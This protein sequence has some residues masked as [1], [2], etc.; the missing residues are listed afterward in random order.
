MPCLEPVSLTRLIRRF[1]RFDT[2]AMDYLECYWDSRLVCS[3]I[4]LLLRVKY[5]IHYFLV[6]ST[7]GPFLYDSVSHCFLVGS[8]RG[9][10]LYM[11]AYLTSFT[12]TASICERTCFPTFQTSIAFLLFSF[13]TNRPRALLIF[14]TVTRVYIVQNS[15]E[16]SFGRILITVA[17]HL[18]DSVYALR[19][20]QLCYVISRSPSKPIQLC[21]AYEIVDCSLN[22]SFKFSLFIVLSRYRILILSVFYS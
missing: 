17:T 5:G 1:S 9:P 2:R 21:L 22:P 8:T 18:R 7:L 16:P 19:L 12:S 3:N 13:S 15:V 20:D 11:T 14:I 6:G 10:F 4:E